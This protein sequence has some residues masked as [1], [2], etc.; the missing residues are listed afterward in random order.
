MNVEVEAL[1]KVRKKV[2]VI[3]PKERISEIR[4]SIYEELKKKAKIKGFRPGKVPRSI[5]SSYYKDYIDE[6]LQN[7]MVQSTMREALVVSKVDPITEP[8]VNFIDEDNRLGYELECEV[9]PEI[10][11]PSYKGVE[12][13]V[14]AINITDDDVEKRIDG[15]QHMHAQMIARENDAMAQKGDFIVI[16]YQGYMNGK[17]VKGIGTDYYPLELGSTTLMPEF[18]AGLI[19]MKTGEEKEIEITFSDDY[20]DK[21]IASKTMQFH[22]FVKE[23]KEKRLPEINDEFAKDL[24]FENMEAMKAGMKEEIYKEKETAQQRD[25]SQK[26]METILKSSDIPVPKRLL[27]KRVQGMIEDAM[28]RFKPDSLTEEEERNLVGNM[29]VD[30]EPRAEERIRGEIVLKKIADTESIAVNDEEVHERMK[31][32][33][34]DTRRNYEEIEKFY[35]EYNMVDNLRASIVEEKT[36]NFL[37]D[38]AIVKEKQ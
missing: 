13:E 4:E 3:L 37:R 22:V 34:E 35:R 7:R 33:A 23:I 2:Q 36:L 26:I 11:L 6:E 25:I 21:E 29:R 5:I 24:N 31:K 15:L 8:I 9:V 10:E 17:P 14:E 16:K 12:V 27:D 28:N 19:G 38:N 18:E 20:P 32:M 30:F 1:D